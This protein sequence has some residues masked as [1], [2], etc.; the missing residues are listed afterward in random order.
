MVRMMPPASLPPLVGV[1][2]AALGALRTALLR[3]AGWSYVGWLTEMGWAGGA[4]AL[5]AFGAW[6]PSVGETRPV[7]ALDAATFQQQAAAFFA[8]AGW[9]SL[10][11]GTLGPGLLTLDSSDWVEADPAAALPYPGCYVSG[12]MFGAFFSAI[13]GVTLTAM[14]VECR[15]TGATRCR[16]L[17]G[18]PA[19]IQHVYDAMAQGR[20]Y[21]DAAV[22]VP[23]A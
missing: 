2:R 16:W 11:I 6:L 7:D 3:D 20:S 18:S 12:G 4:E 23:A 13:G 15:S 21:A 9:G 22:T 17:L 5:H 14:E 19:A 8:A 1:P 10:A